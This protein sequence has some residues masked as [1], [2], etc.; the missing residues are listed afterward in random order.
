MSPALDDLT[1]W[2]GP[3]PD[4]AAHWVDV[5]LVLLRTPQTDVHGAPLCFRLHASPSA[6]L[7]SVPAAGVVSAEY[8]RGHAEEDGLRAVGPWSA[9]RARATV[10]STTPTPPASSAPTPL[11]SATDLGESVQG[12][13]DDGPAVGVDSVDGADGANVARSGLAGSAGDPDAGRGVGPPMGPSSDAVPARPG[14]PIV[15]STPSLVALE[16]AEA[17]ALSLAGAPPA[18]PAAGCLWLEPLG[19]AEVVAPDAVA[20]RPHLRGC[21]ALRPRPPAGGWGPCGLAGAARALVRGQLAV[22]TVDSNG[23]VVRLTGVQIPG[24][25]DATCPY[26]GPL[27]AFVD[28]AN[29]AVTISVWAPTA[30]SVVLTLWSEPRGGVPFH[31]AEMAPGALGAWHARGPV[32]TSTLTTTT[33][34]MMTTGDDVGQGAAPRRGWDRAYYRLRIRAYHPQTGRIEDMETSDPYARGCAAD[35]ERALVV[36]LNDPDTQ[37]PGWEDHLRGHGRPAA[38]DDAV[39]TVVYEMHLRDASSADPGCPP[40]LRGKY[41]GLAHPEALHTRH[42]SS[43]AEAGVTHLHLLP[44]YDFA[45]VPERAEDRVDLDVEVLAAS[46][47]RQHPRPHPDGGWGASEEP[48]AALARVK[49]VDS[50]NWGYDPVHTFVPEG[51]YASQPDGVARTLELRA[52]VVRLHALG[53]RVVLDV[54]YNHMYAAGPTSRYSVLD[55]VVPGYYH[56]YSEQGALLHSTCCND[57]ATEHRLMDRLVVDDI[58]HWAREYGVDGFRF[59]IMGHL[60]RSTVVRAQDALRQLSVEVDG[61]DGA[62]LLLYGEGWNFADMVNNGRGVN[63]HAGNMVGTGIGSFNDRLRDRALGGSPFSDVRCQG[64]ATGLS[65]SPWP[66]GLGPEQGTP[67]QQLAELGRHT[68]ALRACLLGS[69]A[70]LRIPRTHESGGGELDCSQERYPDG[71]LLAWCS[72]PGESVNYVACHDNRTLFD[73]VVLKFPPGTPR[74]RLVRSCVLSHALVL[75][76]QGAPFLA[77]GDELLR[78]KCLDRDSYDSG[79][80]FNAL[81]WTGGASAFGQLGLPPAEKNF[82]TW[83]QLGDRLTDASVRPDANDVAVARAW[84]LALLRV[85]RSTALLRLRSEEAILHHARVI[86]PDKAGVV[87]AEIHSEPHG[88]EGGQGRGQLRACPRFC[89]IVIAL[90][91]GVN[92]VD[93]SLPGNGLRLH[94]D[95]AELEWARAASIANGGTGL[96]LPGQTAVVLVEDWA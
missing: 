94:P 2:T 66:E 19:L 65:S 64:F 90:N 86:C 12:N 61:V 95:L 73:H 91:G 84:T 63:A 38:V 77:A 47:A 93:L 39:D 55:K 68:D 50:Y 71:S 42:L 74:E 69:L 43:L 22:S 14:R 96:R 30:Q 49:G 80:W 72:A 40:A 87:V 24:V 78:S 35:G 82:D 9:A 10:S 79:D 13:G 44:L 92:A 51:S 28:R 31:Q 52:L 21:L 53:L 18:A 62:G 34:T 37:P 4:A 85:R 32:A 83:S 26:D 36:D 15:S 29:D 33:T 45:T 5:D 8:P 67:A 27:G 3:P 54:V 70:S 75:L 81:D 60:M 23:R 20:H 1:G 57:T 76:S 88:W 17:K 59:D 48:Q 89:R 11:G 16:A 7:R 46:L 58:T 41:D 25:L 6:S 56:R